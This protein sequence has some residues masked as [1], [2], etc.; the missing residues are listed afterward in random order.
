MGR[1]S[2]R[3]TGVEEPFDGLMCHALRL[4]RGHDDDNL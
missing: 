1:G 4:K 2:K 3:L